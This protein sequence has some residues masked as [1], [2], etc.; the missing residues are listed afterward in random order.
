MIFIPG[1]YKESANIIKEARSLGINATILG[2]DLWQNDSFINIGKDSV[3]DVIFPTFFDETNPLTDESKKFIDEYF[4][5]YYQAPTCIAANAYDAYLLILHGLNY[6]NS[7][8]PAD[9]RNGMS[10]TKNLEG[11]TGYI[12]MDSD[13]NP[14]KDMI[15][16]TVKDGAFTYKDIV[17]SQ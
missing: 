12:I 4:K 6:N 8:D 16:F 13:R 9:I 3:E 7:A 11:A 1:N 15:L 10:L 5:T 2:D 17:K 14:I